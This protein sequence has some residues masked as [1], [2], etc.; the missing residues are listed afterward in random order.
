MRTRWRNHL[1]QKLSIRKAK[2]WVGWWGRSKFT[3][4]QVKHQIQKF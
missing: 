4:F 1:S 3:S 2:P